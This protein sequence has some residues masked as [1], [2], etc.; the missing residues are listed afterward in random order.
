MGVLPRLTHAPGHLRQGLK[1]ET[2]ETVPE[3]QKLDVLHSTGV[4]AKCSHA[5]APSC[6]GSTAFLAR[7][8]RSGR[9]SECSGESCAEV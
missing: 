6:E 5:V 1:L 2:L 7:S 8:R 3:F 4:A 9:E